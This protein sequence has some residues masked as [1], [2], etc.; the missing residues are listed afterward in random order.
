MAIGSRYV[1]GGGS[2]QLAAATPGDLRGGNLYV[3]LVLGIPVHDATAGFKAFRRHALESIGAVQLGVQRLLLPDREHLAREPRSGC[4]IA[5]VPITFTDRTLGDLEDDQ[6]HRPRSDAAGADLAL[7]R[8]GTQAGRH[9]VAS[10]VGAG[11]M[12][13]PDQLLTKLTSPEV[14]TFLAVGG[15]GYVVDVT[16]LQ[17]VALRVVPRAPWT[18]RTRASLAVGAWPWS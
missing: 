15:V 6:R 8:A 12:W 13:R 4:A 1:R 16:S 9:A 7:A 3:R 17:P 10:P 14:V 5:E 18:R 11:A 2:S